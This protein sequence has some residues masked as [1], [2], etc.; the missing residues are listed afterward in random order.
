MEQVED[1]DSEEEGVDELHYTSNTSVVGIQYYSGMCL[2]I[3]MKCS[4]EALVG[5]VG[6]GEQVRLVREPNNR[7]DRSAAV[8]SAR[9]W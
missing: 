2:V 7:Y 8:V 3:F 9:A 6:A 5:M 4:T 1:D